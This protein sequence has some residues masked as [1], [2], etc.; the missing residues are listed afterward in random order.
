MNRSTMLTAALI[1]VLAWGAAPAPFLASAVMA[2][3]ALLEAGSEE[4]QA[5]WLPRIATGASRIGVAATELV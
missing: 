5:R 4:Q 3:I 1:L 2:P